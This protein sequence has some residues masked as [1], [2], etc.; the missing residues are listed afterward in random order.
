MGVPKPLMPIGGSPLI[1]R[2][3]QQLEKCN[4]KIAEVAVVV[5]DL[6]FAQYDE[7]LKKE[8]ESSNLDIKLVNDGTRSNEDRLGAVACIQVFLL[9]ERVICIY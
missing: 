8:Q 3:V 6:H 5:N 2:W 1:S 7:W 9:S 4:H